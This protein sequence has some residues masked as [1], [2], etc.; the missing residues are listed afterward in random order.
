MTVFFLVSSTL[1]SM[2]QNTSN[3]HDSPRAKHSM[4]AKDRLKPRI[5]LGN[6]QPVRRVDIVE[7]FE[8][9]KTISDECATG[10]DALSMSRNTSK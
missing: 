10:F 7:S 1:N 8:L 6:E 2:P 5:Q 4:T 9:P 3:A